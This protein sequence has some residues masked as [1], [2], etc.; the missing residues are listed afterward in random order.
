MIKPL[1]INGKAVLYFA[2]GFFAGGLSI[3]KRGELIPGTEAL[4][5]AVAGVMPYNRLKLMSRY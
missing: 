3:E 1:V 2:Q 5:V 4:Y